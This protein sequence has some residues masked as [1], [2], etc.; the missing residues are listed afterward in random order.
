[1]TISLTAGLNGIVGWLEHTKLEL[2]CV[3]IHFDCHINIDRTLMDMIHSLIEN[4]S[5]QF[6]SKGG[7]GGRKM[8]LMKPAYVLYKKAYRLLCMYL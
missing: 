6:S 7:W 8:P 2:W 4:P 3:C 5:P 1:M